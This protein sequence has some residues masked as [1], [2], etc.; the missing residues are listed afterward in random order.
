MRRLFSA[1]M[2][3]W[4]ATSRA[5]VNTIKAEKAN[6]LVLNVFTET[7]AGYPFMDPKEGRHHST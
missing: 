4:G 6:E 5:N 3:D 2:K 1:G 7:L